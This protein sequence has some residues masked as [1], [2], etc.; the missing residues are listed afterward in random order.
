[1][2]LWVFVKIFM[3]GGLWKAVNL[4]V[5]LSSL[6]FSRGWGKKNEHEVGRI[7]TD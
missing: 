7:R 2:Q 1:M 3:E 6:Y 5:G 4:L